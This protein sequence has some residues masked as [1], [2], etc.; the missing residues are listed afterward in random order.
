MIAA[1][2][3]QPDG[4]YS[5]LPDVD[6]WPESRDARRYDGPHPVVAHPPCQRW[7][8]MHGFVE[9]VYPGRFKLGDDGGCFASALASVRKYGG[10]LEHPE[11][12]RAWAHFGLLEPPRGGG[13]IR[14]DVLDGFDGWT[15]CL[16]QGA[17]GHPARKRTW[18]Y[19]HG[20]DVPSM[21]WGSANGHFPWVSFLEYN[22]P[23]GRRRAIRTGICQRLSKRQRAATPPAFR[24]VL[25]A[26]ARSVGMQADA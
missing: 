14:A 15:C 13:W 16:D 3:V 19:A 10:V 2:Y 22:T 8:R 21:R 6:L 18:L 26:M 7:T 12:S 1:L 4:V 11:G 24:D 20:V 17:F 9:H 25:L 23:E 5:G